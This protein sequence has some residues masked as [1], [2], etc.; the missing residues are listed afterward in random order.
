MHFIAY[1][2]AQERES[3]NFDEKYEE[4][5]RVNLNAILTNSKEDSLK[6]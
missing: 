6:E 5:I 1:D 3:L 4:E 2:P